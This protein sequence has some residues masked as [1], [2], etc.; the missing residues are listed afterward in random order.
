MKKIIS[1][2]L[3]LS[4]IFCLCATTAFASGTYS[5]GRAIITAF[6]NFSATEDTLTAE[7]VSNLESDV[8]WYLTENRLQVIGTIPSADPY[9]ILVSLDSD[10]FTEATETNENYEVLS[11]IPFTDMLRIILKDADDNNMYYVELNDIVISSVEAYNVNWYH[12]FLAPAVESVETITPNTIT[13]HNKTFS[14]TTTI[15]GD[16][17]KEILVLKFYNDWDNPVTSGVG[18]TAITKMTV[19]SKTTELTRYGTTTPVV[20]AGNSLFVNQITYSAVTPYGEYLRKVEPQFTGTVYRSGSVGIGVGIAIPH[21]PFS[22][23]L[24]SLPTSETK[25]IGS[26]AVYFDL[27]DYADAPKMPMAIK[28]DYTDSNIWLEDAANEVNSPHGIVI[29]C[30]LKTHDSY[31]QTGQKGFGYRW[32]YRVASDGNCNGVAVT[33]FSEPQY[34][35]NTLYYTLNS[36]N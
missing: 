20:A 12:S 13:S 35:K 8:E 28:V 30:S 32:D 10:Q 26:S 18:Y 3:C 24:L 11:I 25:T 16:V 1:I 23:D 29:E 15:Y 17:Y 36:S 2:I 7:K 19:Q 14:T 27:D 31:I 33:M 21:T 9:D 22:I 5:N 34:F 4:L 6:E